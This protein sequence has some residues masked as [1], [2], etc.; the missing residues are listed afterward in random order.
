LA[1]GANLVML[2]AMPGR[3]APEA[4]RREQ[5]LAAAF[6]IASKKRLEGLTIR[7]VAAKAG[8]S[9]GLVLF[10]FKSRDTLLVALLDWLLASTVIGEPTP[11]VLALPT[12]HARLFGLLRQELLLL[13]ERRTRLELF[14]DYW[15]IGIGHPRIR[16][17]IRKAL[18]R[19]RT[20]ILPLA[21]D[22]VSEAPSRF[23]NMSGADLARLIAALIEGCVIQAIVDPRGFDVAQVMASLALFDDRA[24]AGVSTKGRRS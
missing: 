24:Q 20:T 2:P 13:P 16:A 6:A 3:R 10:H 4:A 14:F 19:Y 1:A 12:A 11:E 8:L 9:P 22:A 18:E 15:V 21:E 7:A 23:A 17:R 5:I